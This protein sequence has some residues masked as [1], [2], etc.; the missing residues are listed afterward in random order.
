MI[1]K[2]SQVQ[3][4]CDRDSGRRTLQGFLVRFIFDFYNCEPFARQSLKSFA[5]CYDDQ[6]AIRI[7]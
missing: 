1:H 3:R 2:V 7:V 6:D 5:N 4:T